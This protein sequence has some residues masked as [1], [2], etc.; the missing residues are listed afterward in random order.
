MLETG[1]VNEEQIKK[2]YSARSHFFSTIFSP[3][4]AIEEVAEGRGVWAACRK[5]TASLRRNFAKDVSKRGRGEQT[6]SHFYLECHP[7]RRLREVQR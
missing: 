2:K 5:C 6:P 7:T 1:Y 4:D 3:F